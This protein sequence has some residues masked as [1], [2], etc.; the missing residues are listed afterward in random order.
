M[1]KFLRSDGLVPTKPRSRLLDRPVRSVTLRVRQGPRSSVRKSPFRWLASRE[2]GKAVLCWGISSF[3]PGNQAQGSARRSA[4]SRIGSGLTH[5]SCGLQSCSSP[6]EVGRGGQDFNAS[7]QPLDPESVSGQAFERD[8]CCR[9]VFW[10]M[11]LRRHL[12]GLPTKKR[13]RGVLL[14]LFAG[15]LILVMTH[16]I[17]FLMYACLHFLWVTAELLKDGQF[18]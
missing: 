8:R 18:D 5:Q 4:P 9:T 15:F 16:S 13:S 1:V 6:A 17:C 3:Y 7:V 11:D 10:T 2:R 14:W 12:W